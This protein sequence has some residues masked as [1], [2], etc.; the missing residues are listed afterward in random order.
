MQIVYAG[1][2]NLSPILAIVCAGWLVYQFLDEPTQRLVRAVGCA[3]ILV[4]WVYGRAAEGRL[5]SLDTVLV[6]VVFAALAG[7]Y[8]L[9]A[10][11]RLVA[12]AG[13][14]RA[15]GPAEDVLGALGFVSVLALWVEMHLS[16]GEL[17]ELEALLGAVLLAAAAAMSGLAAL[18]HWRGS[19]DTLRWLSKAT[20]Y[21]SWGLT[22]ILWVAYLAPWDN[23]GRILKPEKIPLAI[24][25]G[26]GAVVLLVVVLGNR[27]DERR[28]MLQWP[29]RRR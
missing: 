28:K 26:V 6:A 9:G 24:A 17:L 13:A 19:T 18:E 20:R 11:K 29:D 21:V 16:E 10:I 5:G 3:G 14:V 23:L 7:T 12:R 15:E 4:F 27:R 2:P 22:L 8:V 25:V 1:I